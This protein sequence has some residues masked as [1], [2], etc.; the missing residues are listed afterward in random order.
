MDTARRTVILATALGT[1]LPNAVAF[2]GDVASLSDPWTS[3]RTAAIVRIEV[4][5][6]AAADPSVGTGF[7][8]KGL[9]G[10]HYVLTSSHVV[11][12]ELS[13]DKA[14]PSGCANLLTKTRLQENNAGGKDLS[15][16]CVYHVGQDVS[17]IQLNP[18][19]ESYH[20]LALSTRNVAKDELLS[21]AGFPLG[22]PRVTRS[23]K[24]TSLDGPEETIIT[25]ILTAEGM[26]GGPYLDTQ[27]NVVG[28]HLGGGRYTAG[29]PYAK[30]IW[31]LRTALQSLLVLDQ[32]A[33]SASSDLCFDGQ[34]RALLDKREPFSHEG[35][36]TCGPKQKVFSDVLRYDA[37]L[38]RPGY[39]IAGFVS[40]IDQVRNGFA[41]MLRYSLDGTNVFVVEV[42]VDCNVSFD[43]ADNEEGYVTVRIN[44]FLR[45]LD[46]K[47]VRDEAAQACR[48]R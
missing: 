9:S 31:R 4:Q 40:H 3:D 17:L 42:P 19:D 33:T 28:I 47:A 45:R 32:P 27:G 43:R 34:M 1:F 48:N 23:G 24:V 20:V 15:P 10:S 12:P 8:V 46:S 35:R 36:I 30:P 44:G 41:G 5:T 21:I 37:R 13:N 25:E 7:I 22:N 11:L 6:S 29:Y 14:P 26:S 16:K 18:R 2:S 39:A 38:S